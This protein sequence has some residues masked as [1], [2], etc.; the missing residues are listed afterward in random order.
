LPEIKQFICLTCG[1]K[2]ETS[3]IEPPC[4]VL[5]GWVMATEWKEC[6]SVI[7]HMFCSFSCLKRWVDTSVPAVP[8]VFMKSFS[9]NEDKNK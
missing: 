3:E 4:E 8:D 6:E 9:E 5:M 2:V 7:Q 1:K